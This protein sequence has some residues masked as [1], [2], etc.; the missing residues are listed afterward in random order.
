MRGLKVL[1]VIGTFLPKQSNKDT[2]G[3]KPSQGSTIGNK[4]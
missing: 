4:G 3:V 1:S 2:K